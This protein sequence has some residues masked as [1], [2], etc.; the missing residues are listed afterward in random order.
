MHKSFDTLFRSPPFRVLILGD[1]MID[2]YLNGKVTRISPEAPV[3]VVQLD[4][5]MDRLG[6]AANVALNIKAMGA[7]ATLF[8]VIGPDED[9]DLFR[10]LSQKDEIFTSGLI[11]EKGRRTTV[12]TRVIAG[13][14][15]LLRLDVED[16]FPLNEHT[17]KILLEAI[18]HAL[19]HMTPDVVIL[20]DYNK[21]VLS[22]NIILEVIRMATQ[23][24]IPVAVD[25]KFNHFLSYKGA[26]L[27][28]PNHKELCEGLGRWVPTEEA[29]LEKACQELHTH[30]GHGISL[31][32]LSDKG[33][34]WYDH[35]IGQGGIVP[36]VQRD[37]VDV[38]G[39][40]DTVIAV[41]ALALA[42]RWSATDIAVVANLAGGQVC[43]KVGVVPINKESL[44]L[45][46]LKV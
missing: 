18:S 37:I 41:A 4:H 35:G 26:T 39:A 15:H 2:R 5:S 11:P 42:A 8:A 12:K 29:D 19:D 28:K 46:Y 3:P 22:E 6:G 1:V 14:Q 45:E 13:N 40:G 36:P 33:I 21:G 16:T 27:F 20:Q 24:S 7:T 31:I 30:L 44:D 9:G 23:R 10:S 43:E 38:C 34:Y 25:P 32:T 17:E